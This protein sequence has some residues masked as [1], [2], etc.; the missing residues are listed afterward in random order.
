MNP[1]AMTDEA[2]H[3]AEEDRL[4]PVKRHM[5]A[6]IRACR[7]RLGM[8]LE[9]LGQALGVAYQQVQ[10]YEKGEN[11]I[12][13]DRLP[14]LSRVLQVPISHFFEGLPRPGFAEPQQ[15][16][17]DPAPDLADAVARIKDPETRGH[18]L[19]LIKRLGEADGP[20]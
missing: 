20:R 14:D 5:G 13:A 3:G 19:A 10:K 17:G 8:S 12:G 6:R 7:K 18:L 1:T 4:R 9:D 15:E 11:R 16:L 2:D